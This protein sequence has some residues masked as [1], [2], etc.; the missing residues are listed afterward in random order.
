MN[1][2]SPFNS[3]LLL[4]STPA[5]RHHTYPRVDPMKETEQV[6]E[7]MISNQIL[8]WPITTQNFCAFLSKWNLQIL[9]SWDIWLH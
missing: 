1:F 3:A 8:K 2:S 4:F 6:S 9:H 7:M 5:N